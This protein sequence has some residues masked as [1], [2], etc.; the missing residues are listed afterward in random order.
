[1]RI[2]DSY[3]KE[4]SELSFYKLRLSFDIFTHSQTKCLILTLRLV[5]TSKGKGR[6][7]GKNFHQAF[8]IIR[9][10]ESEIKI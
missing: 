1:M 5:I 9:R 8:S 7:K 3:Q 4:V 2:L 10:K 6:N